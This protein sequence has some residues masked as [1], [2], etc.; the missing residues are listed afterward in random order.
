MN[1]LRATSRAVRPAAARIKRSGPG[2]RDACRANDVLQERGDDPA[3]EE[4][5]RFRPVEP[6]I[7]EQGR[8]DGK[9]HEHGDREAAVV[10]EEPG[11]FAKQVE[12]ASHAKAVRRAARMPIEAAAS[13]T[14]MSARIAASPYGQWTPMPSPNQKSPNAET[15]T[16]TANLSAFSGTRDSG[17]L[18]NAAATATA[19]QAPI[20]PIVAGTSMFPAAPIPI[21]I[22]ITSTPSSNTALKEVRAAMVSHRFLAAPP[23]ATSAW[24]SLA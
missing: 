12:D 7:A 17:R 14:A 11:D 4:R 23:A 19:T 24:C 1:V 22:T 9:D 5:H 20:A 10:E 2:Q 15:I 8:R 3:H 16:P 13:N 21:T 18:S 6:G